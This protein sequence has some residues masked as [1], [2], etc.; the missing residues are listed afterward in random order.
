ADAI[1]A[2]INT[3][4]PDN[5]IFQEEKLITPGKDAVPP[6]EAKVVI[7]Y[8]ALNSDAERYILQYDRLTPEGY[9]NYLDAVDTYNQAHPE[10][11]ITHPASLYLNALNAGMPAEDGVARTLYGSDWR[12]TNDVSLDAVQALK[13]LINSDGSINH[14]A[15][16]AY[17]E[18]NFQDRV[19]LGNFVGKVNG[20]VTQRP[21]LY[22]HKDPHSTY[23]E[24]NQPTKVIP[25][26][27]GEDAV[28]PDY[29]PVAKEGGFAAGLIEFF[30]R[31]PE[32][33]QGL[34]ER[35]G[36]YADR[37]FRKE[38]TVVTKEKEVIEHKR[39]KEKE[40]D[41]NEFL[42]REYETIHGH[43]P[44]EAE[45]VR[46]KGLVL[47]EQEAEQ[48]TGGIEQ[49]MQKRW[50]EFEKT[51]GGKDKMPDRVNET[52]NAVQQTNLAYGGQPLKTM[53]VTITHFGEISKACGEGSASPI[54]NARDP[55]RAPAPRDKGNQPYGGT[56]HVDTGKVTGEI[57]PKPQKVSS[58]DNGGRK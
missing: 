14:D 36:G 35:I 57:N 38:K 8:D 7:D 41:V 52:R 34:K 54:N 17:N 9:Q 28:P 25:G 58:R 26:T 29:D 19:G 42:D 20:D 47:K 15:V 10:A 40:I 11:P 1:Q 50:A 31:V 49:Y 30:K 53:D 32:R 22:P 5:Q 48:F 2:R 12:S 51:I 27:P 18:H 23:S 43:K 24:M 46:Y 37:L 3:M 6:T 44:N 55:K 4:F 13:G 16:Q 21:D 56:F 39:K 45:R 33:V